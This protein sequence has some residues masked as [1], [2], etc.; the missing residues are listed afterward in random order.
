MSTSACLVKHLGPLRRGRMK[1][2]PVAD[3]R[4]RSAGAHKEAKQGV[5]AE[6]WG[7]AAVAQ[8]G[9]KEIKRNAPPAHAFRQTSLRS[10]ALTLRGPHLLHCLT[11]RS[12]CISGLPSPLQ[13]PVYPASFLVA[14]DG[15]HT[16]THPDGE[17]YSQNK[18]VAESARSR[19]Q[20]AGTGCYWAV[21]MALPA[22]T[23][24]IG[25]LLPLGGLL[26]RR[27]HQKPGQSADGQEGAEL[28][29]MLRQSPITIM[30]LR[31][32]LALRRP[33]SSQSSPFSGPTS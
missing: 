20:P 13:S 7:R 10:G 27:P 14:H 11:D 12:C 21:D 26:A 22:Q 1:P 5:I 4:Q 28:S 2:G 25:V 23:G 8:R 18:S 32:S 33:G 6:L 16:I 9:V 30:G 29:S 31:Q 17:P 19:V 24:G 15:G 3:V